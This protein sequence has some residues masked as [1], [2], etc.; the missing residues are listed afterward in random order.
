MLDP[1]KQIL[2]SP[3]AGIVDALTALGR[4]AGALFMFATALLAFVRTKD[5]AG[6]A[7]YLQA[8][9][10]AMIG[11]VS[12]LVTAG[13]IA[14]GVVKTWFRGRQVANVAANPDV[15]PQIADLK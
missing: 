15:P 3:N 12:G 6:M 13:I 9:G 8:N 14:Y 7:A 1:D 5:L 4:Y 2:V 11:A 10:G